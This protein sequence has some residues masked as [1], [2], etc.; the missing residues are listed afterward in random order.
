MSNKP[1]NEC[2]HK[3]TDLLKKTLDADKGRVLR[4]IEPSAVRVLP[5]QAAITLHKLSPTAV[6]RCS[7]TDTRDHILHCQGVIRT[8]L[9]GTAPPTTI[10]EHSCACLCSRTV[11]RRVHLSPSWS[12][13]TGGVLVSVL[14][15]TSTW[16]SLTT[17]APCVLCEHFICI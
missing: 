15:I 10:R 5:H 4:C 11:R 12:C 1:L 3:Y 14:I 2:T 16:H 6:L 9:R 8:A 13:A 17:K 7:S